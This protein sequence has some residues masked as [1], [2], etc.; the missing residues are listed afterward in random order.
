MLVLSKS[1]VV[2][3]EILVPLF[4]KVMF[5][6]G[7]R[8]PSFVCG[9]PSDP[10]LLPVSLVSAVGVSMAEASVVAVGAAVCSLLSL[11]GACGNLLAVAVLCTGK[12]PV[13]LVGCNGPP[14]PVA[15]AMLRVMVRVAVDTV[16][17]RVRGE[18]VFPVGAIA[19][20]S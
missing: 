12:K 10:V 18:D 14:V 20:S 8:I 9:E 11:V 16:V 15:S 6:L 1:K 19:E 3:G 5:L 7:G 17:V 2:N 13:P 4:A